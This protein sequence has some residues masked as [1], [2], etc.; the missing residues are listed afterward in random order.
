MLGFS[1]LGRRQG[2]G[3][4]SVYGRIDHYE[5]ART[6]HHVETHQLPPVI[7]VFAFLKR[8]KR[9]DQALVQPNE[10]VLIHWLPSHPR[11]DRLS[12]D[13]YRV[14]ITVQSSN[15][16]DCGHSSSG[17]P[18]SGSLRLWNENPGQYLTWRTD[19]TVSCRPI[20]PAWGR[21]RICADHWASHTATRS[22]V[23]RVPLRTCL[24]AA[25][26]SG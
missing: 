10:L 26:L 13:M 12:R 15:A 9:A 25:S 2:I 19:Q 1:V 8:R 17:V 23:R 4:E 22:C 16:R 6:A 24:V 18:C 7:G 11:P 3:T 20:Y 5:A 14:S 21:S